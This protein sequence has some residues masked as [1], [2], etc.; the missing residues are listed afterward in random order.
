MHDTAPEAARIARDALRR[1]DPVDRMRRAL[2]H[3]ETM[4][5][6]AHSETM[7]ALALARLRVRHPGLPTVALV[8]LLL[9]EPLVTATADL[10][11]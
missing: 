6:L 5:A 7:R 1:T 2:A 10:T 3:S 9:G 4:R 8:E 11:E